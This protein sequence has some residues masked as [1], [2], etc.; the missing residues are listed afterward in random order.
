MNKQIIL[1]AC[2]LIVLLGCGTES[3]KQER[4][5]TEIRGTIDSVHLLIDY[6]TDRIDTLATVISRHD[7]LDV[8]NLLINLTRRESIALVTREYAVGTMVEQIG[9]RRNGDGGYWV[10]TVNSEAIPRAASAYV[11]QPGDTI[12]FLFR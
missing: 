4:A 7:S 9:E 11:V 3:A 1:P 10:Y 6:A 2:A 5:A 8:L 12:R